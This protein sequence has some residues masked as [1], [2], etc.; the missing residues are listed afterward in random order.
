[1]IE[2]VQFRNFQTVDAERMVELQ[3]RCLAHCPDTG[4][5]E[6]G[7]WR[8]PGYQD[9]KNIII[10]EDENVRI[11]GYA[12]T[13]S[14]YY[15][16]TLEARVFWIDLRTDPDFDK[17]LEIKDS[18]LERII[19]RGYEIKKEENRERAAMGATYFSQGLASIDY[20]KSHGFNHFET[21]LA[22]R[23]ELSDT[24][25]KP[26]QIPEIQ[27]KPWKMEGREEKQAYLD[28]REL[29]FG[30]PLGRLDLLEH[31]THS[32]LWLGGTTFT[33]FS[34]G[35]IIASVMALSNGLLD[36]VFVIPE[37][38]GKGIAKVLVSMALKYLKEQ[39]HKQ[40]W[41]EV[42]SHNTPALRLYQKFGFKTFKEEISLGY[43]LD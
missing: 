25:P 28:A 22:M 16:N 31:F 18:L 6:P 3:G 14:A 13:S 37:W 1:M 20:L 42:Y 41:L 38:R 43:L 33:A 26:E 17:H 29:A 4:K 2:N 12:A 11:V 39:N 10:A 5:F 21:M 15:S 24:I 35:K 9:G 7:F 30:Y 8:S 32:K 34:E 36:Y 40:A 23:R 19:K 27:I